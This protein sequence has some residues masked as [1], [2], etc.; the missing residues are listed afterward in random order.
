MLLSGTFAWFSAAFFAAVAPTYLLS[1]ALPTDCT[2]SSYAP[3]EVSK[4]SSLIDSCARSPK[5]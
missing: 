3:E 2:L 1:L 4:F 5:V